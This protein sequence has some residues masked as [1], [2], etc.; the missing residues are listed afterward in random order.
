MHN[1]HLD[2]IHSSYIISISIANKAKDKFYKN[3]LPLL[4]NVSNEFLVLV[5]KCLMPRYVAIPFVKLPC[6]YNNV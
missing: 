2:F 5:P 6:Q 3:D 4:E 1:I